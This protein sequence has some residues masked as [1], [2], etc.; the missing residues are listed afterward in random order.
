MSA[1]RI[2]ALVWVTLITAAAHPAFAQGAGDYQVEIGDKLSVSVYGKEELSGIF[3][4]R[5][6]GAIVMHLLGEIDAAGATFAEIEDR[7]VT[8]AA[9]K[10][11]SNESALVDIAEFRSVFVL[12]AVQTP[13]AYEY[14]PGLNVMK[15]IALAGGY[16]TILAETRAE[17]DVETAQRRIVEAQ[18]RLRFALAEK[19]AI[20]AE[21]ARLEGAEDA[22][23]DTSEGGLE[24]DQ[25]ELVDLR[26]SLSERT[27]EGAER[28][29]SLAIDEAEL[30]MQRRELV[31]GQLAATEEQLASMTDL[32]ERGLARRDQVLSLQVDLN[33]LRADALEAAAFEARARQTAANAESD[34]N[35]EQTQ[36]RHSL[37][38]DKIQV[39][40]D[41]I[42]QRSDLET[43]LAFL[44]E[45][46]PA[47][48]EDMGTGFVV[49]VY[50]IFRSGAA[51][52]IDAD[53]TTPLGPDDTLTVRFESVSTE[54]G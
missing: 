23:V 43:N 35:V 29:Q 31:D 44:R 30:L 22:V 11:S 12:G 19:A 7:I 14:R 34:L 4:V 40:Q 21:L 38:Q 39:E 13:G 27:A 32:A 5:G 3:R 51:E 28:R 26:R 9:E 36:Y 42:V 49:T 6:D 45:I 47:A 2:L 1:F 18:N 24:G 10:F 17:R 8:R 15:A 33:N 20:D 54:Q 48:A 37:L 41:V 46:S 53:L 16:E 50:E 25:L 52:P